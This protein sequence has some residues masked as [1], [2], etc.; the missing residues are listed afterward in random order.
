MDGCYLLQVSSE[1]RSIF[2]RNR[3]LIGVMALTFFSVV[4]VSALVAY[5]LLLISPG[6]AGFLQGIMG[7]ATAGL[8]IPAPY[9]T[10]LYRL[11]FFNNIGHF[12]NPYRIWVWLPAIG[13]L[14]LGYELVLNAVVIGGVITL[15]AMT[16]GVAFTVAGLAPHGILEIPAFILEFTALARWHVSTIRALY[17]KLSGRKVD[18]PLLIQG[19]KDTIFLSLLSVALF[20][21]AAYIETFITPRFLGLK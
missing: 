9:T 10:D 6:L 7:S 17:A 3:L 12:W 13:L 16:R 14:S 20:A 2:R 21:G 8:A 4:V 1:I 11:I 15:S 18:R 19:V 5:L